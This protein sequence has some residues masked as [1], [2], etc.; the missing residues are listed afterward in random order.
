[1]VR[2]AASKS[3]AVFQVSTLVLSF[4]YRI[5][6]MHHTGQNHISSIPNKSSDN[7]AKFKYLGTAVTNKICIREEIKSTVNS[8]NACY[9]SVQNVFMSPL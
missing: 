3:A 9:H 4:L 8:R 6:R 2:K 7:L 1:V 5:K